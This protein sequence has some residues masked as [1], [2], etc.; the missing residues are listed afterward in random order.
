MKFTAKENR[1][2]EA[3]ERG[4]KAAPSWIREFAAVCNE[5]KFI[6]KEK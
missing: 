3:G 1:N 2:K 5:M 6:A 4:R